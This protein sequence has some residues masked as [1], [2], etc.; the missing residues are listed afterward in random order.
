MRQARGLLLGQGL[1]LPHHLVDGANTHAEALCGVL[2]LAVIFDCRQP[3]EAIYLVRL[4]IIIIDAGRPS[5]ALLLRRTL[6]ANC[7]LSTFER[8]FRFATNDVVCV[9]HFR[10]SRNCIS[11]A[12]SS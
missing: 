8:L 2:T 1:L 11:V 12:T 5:A 10:R 9:G 4:R 3:R 7:L 6:G